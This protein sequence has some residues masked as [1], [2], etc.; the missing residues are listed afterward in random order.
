MPLAP[1]INKARAGRVAILAHIG[2]MESSQDTNSELSDADLLREC[3]RAEIAS[4]YRH[5]MTDEQ[6]LQVS[7]CVC[8]CVCVLGHTSPHPRALARVHVCPS[9]LCKH[10]SIRCIQLTFR[11][12]VM[13]SH[14]VS[15]TVI[16]SAQTQTVNFYVEL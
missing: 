15:I 14:A 9:R 5:G 3:D 11:G 1:G 13:T 7:V 2:D 16:L 8:V 4:L 6:L 10:S 12:E